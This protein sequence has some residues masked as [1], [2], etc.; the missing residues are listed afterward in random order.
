LLDAGRGHVIYWLGLYKPIANAVW[1]TPYAQSK[2]EK[3]NYVMH[4]T[5]GLMNEAQCSKQMAKCQKVNAVG[6]ELNAGCLQFTMHARVNKS[7]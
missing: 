7:Y 2:V 3:A 6:P 1:A 5:K 4:I